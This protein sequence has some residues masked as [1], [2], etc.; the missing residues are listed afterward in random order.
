MPKP[1]R[2]CRALDVADSSLGRINQR[3]NFTLVAPI[4]AKIAIDRN[5]AVLG[6]E[7]THADKAKIGQ[8]WFAILVAA[9]QGDELGKMRVAI[10]RKANEPLLDHLKNNVAVA[11]VKSRFGQD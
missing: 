7:F 10:K 11:E 1:V 5:H 6:I 4:N 3:D 2:A 8:V 9:S